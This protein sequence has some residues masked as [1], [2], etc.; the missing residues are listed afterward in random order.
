MN[1]S[2]TPSAGSLQ[3]PSTHRRRFRTIAPRPIDP[4]VRMRRIRIARAVNLI[5]RTKCNC[6]VAA[7]ACGLDGDSKALQ[8]IRD[9]L[10]FRR[11]PRR[12]NG[13]RLV[14]VPET[15]SQ[16]FE[17]FIPRQEDHRRATGLAEM[18]EELK[19]VANPLGEDVP[20][21]P[22]PPIIRTCIVCRVSFECKYK[23]ARYCGGA[24]RIGHWRAEQ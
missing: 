7:R 20:R 24:C 17:A 10:D 8:D 3:A 14:R 22:K 9:L 18:L 4:V 23:T 19:A 5:C 15:P 11:I 2:T 16:V 12:R 21:A 6:T 1:D 13:V